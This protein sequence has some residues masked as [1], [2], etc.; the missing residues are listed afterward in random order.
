VQVSLGYECRD[1]PPRTG[2]SLSPL[3]LDSAWDGLLHSS[4]A[5]T[6]SGAE[7]RPAESSR[8][9]Q[10]F[11]QPDSGFDITDPLSWVHAL[12]FDGERPFV[13]NLP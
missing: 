10:I 5:A 11:E 3:R 8:S 13:A 4:Y 7:Y 2:P 6:R 12:A 1:A 9:L